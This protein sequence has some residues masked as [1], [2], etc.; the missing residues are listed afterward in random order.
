M[1]NEQLWIN[2][3]Q[4]IV[5]EMVCVSRATINNK[6]KFIQIAIIFWLLKLG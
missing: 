1:P 2:K 4:N 6:H 3:G 5:A